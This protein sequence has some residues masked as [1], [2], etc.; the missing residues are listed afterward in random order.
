VPLTPRRG[1]A[2][3]LRLLPVRVVLWSLSGC[4]GVLLL[5]ISCTCCCA[6]V[7]EASRTASAPQTTPSSTPA[8]HYYP[9]LVHSRHLQTP[10]PTHLSTPV[11]TRTSTRRH[12]TKQCHISAFASLPLT[13]AECWRTTAAAAFFPGAPVELETVGVWTAAHSCRPG[14]IYNRPIC[15]ASVMERRRGLCPS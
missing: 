8:H 14:S 5:S 6:H 13:K 15:G 3:Y 4:H 9:T 2:S 7:P 11:L 1:G 12:R 10:V